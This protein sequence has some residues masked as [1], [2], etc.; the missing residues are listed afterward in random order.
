MLIKVL[1]STNKIALGIAAQTLYKRFAVIFAQTNMWIAQLQLL[2]LLIGMGTC[3]EVFTAFTDIHQSVSAGRL[4]AEELQAYV[5][6]EKAR[7]ERLHDIIGRLENATQTFNTSENDS[8]SSSTNPVS[9][10]LAILRLASNWSKELSVLFGEPFIDSEDGEDGGELGSSL[11][12]EFDKKRSMFLRLKWYV[13]LLPGTKDIE[14][15][16]DAIIRLQHTYAIGANE[17]ADGH[18]IPT[19]TS[20]KLTGLVFRVSIKIRLFLFQLSPKRRQRM[21][22]IIYHVCV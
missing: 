19:S 3:A 4:L 13:D 2:L 6:K 8:S 21:G 10:F 14:G 11:F 16:S 22:A 1:F 15:A 12:E 20:L 5:T 18:M 9:M 7:I 17:V